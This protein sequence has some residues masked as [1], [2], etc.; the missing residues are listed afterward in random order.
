MSNTPTTP[1]TP[2]TQ[3]TKKGAPMTDTDLIAQLI[4]A[5]KAEVLGLEKF[6]ELEKEIK[7][8]Q[9]ATPE[10][11]EARKARA[12][13]IREIR[14]GRKAQKDLKVLIAQM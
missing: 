4:E 6:E 3:D 14:G 9:I 10:Y 8:L 1:S 12:E 2:E 7:S 5:I 11:R 13:L